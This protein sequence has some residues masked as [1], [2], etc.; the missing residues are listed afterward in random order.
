MIDGSHARNDDLLKRVADS[1][2]DS[3][4]LELQRLVVRE[5]NSSV[6]LE[7][8]VPTYYAKQLAQTL[9]ARIE[10]VT[11]LKNAIEVDRI[12]AARRKTAGAPVDA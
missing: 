7:G 1:L 5:Q 4:R 9:V 8:V 3:N 12:A 10:G 2:R 6:V 11:R